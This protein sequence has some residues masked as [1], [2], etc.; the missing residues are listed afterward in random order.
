MIPRWRSC[1]SRI[2][3]L[4]K[5]LSRWSSF[6][7]SRA[8][9]RHRRRDAPPVWTP[10]GECFFFKCCFWPILPSL[11]DTVT[12]EMM[13]RRGRTGK[14]ELSLSTRALFSKRGMC[15]H[16][17]DVF[18]LANS[19]FLYYF[20]DNLLHKFSFCL[21]L[22][23]SAFKLWSD[24][25]IILRLVLFYVCICILNCDLLFFL[26][27]IEPSAAFFHCKNKKWEFCK[28]KKVEFKIGQVKFNYQQS[29]FMSLI[30]QAFILVRS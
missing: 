20:H 1:R 16:E 19:A 7:R 4:V 26:T 11:I 10:A 12:Q 6:R 18:K 27:S 17:L 22:I 30:C 14:L 3:S 28:G 24:D 8:C 21:F 9:V 23:C 2:L 5:S 13:F 25:I 29:D 15:W